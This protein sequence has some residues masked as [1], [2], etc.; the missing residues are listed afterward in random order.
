VNRVRRPWLRV[1]A[2]LLAGLAV[3]VPAAA[4]GPVRIGGVDLSSYPELRVTVVAPLG[5]QQPRLA[6]NGRP[7]AAIQA[8]NLGRMKSVVLAVDRSRSMAGASLAD[9]VAAAR[10]FVGSK[11]RADRVE[12]VA[13]GRRAVGLTRFSSSSFD[14]DAALR[15]LTI[16]KRSGTALW[17]A[18]ALA[19]RRLTNENAHGRVILVVTDG[20]DVS[21][22]ASLEQAVA[23][24]HWARASVYA[25]GIMGPDF[26]PGPLRELAA[27]TG[28]AYRQASSTAQ[29]AAVY[30]QL[31]RVL[32]RTWEI[33]YPTAARPGEDVRLT[34]T[35]PGA[36][37][38][39][40]TVSLA[41]VQGAGTAAVAPTLL[42][43]NA[44]ISELA[45]FVL[46]LLVGLLVVLACSFWVAAR[47]GHMLRAR[48]D[49][50]LGPARRGVRKHRRRGARSLIRNVFGT[51]EQMF[52]NVKQFRALQ[53]LLVRADLPLRASELLYVC[54]GAGL[55]AGIIAGGL[56]VPALLAI[57]FMAGVATLPILF[58]RF[59]AS[60]RIKSFDNQLPDLLIT[61]AASLKAGHSFRQAVQAVVDEGAEPA[62]SEFNRV[63]AETR[64][65]RPMDDALGDMAQRIG[66]RNFSFV[67]TAVTIQRQIGGSLAG[68][69]DMVA[70][71][72]RQRQQFARKIRGLT[73]MGRMSAYTLIG[74]PFFI[75]LAVTAM[76]P[77]YM[78]PLYNTPTGQKLIA[79]GLGMMA[80]GTVLL[81]KIVSFRG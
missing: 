52:A 39:N 4:A 9:A 20:S 8:T 70:D 7:A 50:H 59:K 64:L 2:I 3:A 48:L 57:V 16:D 40:R 73:A 78:A 33:R 19:A 66:S 37:R 34:A 76:N 18:V 21:S 74:I 49:P 58:V 26:T 68:L 77:T 41:H 69:F 62:A 42:P 43:S 1:P 10:I 79:M 65:G 80:I 12:V 71:T 51:T 81:K 46:M 63:L 47:T 56:G 75:A 22:S 35:V 14:A 28:G 61:I 13:F 55:L 24:A 44:W 31:S 6:E 29:L 27:R 38:T 36:G 32:A 45:P 25:I 60:G 5:A 15:G 30:A 23:A 17:D 67:I 54:L 53:R 72:V 11:G